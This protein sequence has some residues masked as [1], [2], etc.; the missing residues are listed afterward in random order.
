[1][2]IKNKESLEWRFDDRMLKIIPWGNGLRVRET[3]NDFINVDWALTEEVTPCIN[4][5]IDY[6]EKTSS[7]VNG[8]IK[9]VVTDYGKISFFNKENDLILE[10][11]WR[12]RRRKKQVNEE[13]DEFIDD[14]MINEFVSALKVEGRELRPRTEGDYSLTV[15]FE[16]DENEKIYGMGQYQQK[17]LDLKYCTLELA[18]RNSQ[19]SVPFALSSKGYGF[20]WNNPAIGSANFSKNITE[21]KAGD[22]RE[23]D[24]WI[25]A[26]ESPKKI[27]EAYTEV[28]GRTPQIPEYGLG[29]WQSKLRYRTQEELLEVAREYKK[30]NIPISVIVIDYF[31]WTCQG[32]FK[33]DPKFWP[34]PKEMIK[35]LKEMGIELMVSVWPTIDKKSE[36]FDE[37]LE[38]GLLVRSDKGARISMEFQGNTIFFDATNPESRSYVWNKAK[39]NYYDYGVKIF[40]LD[41]AEPEYSPY[42]FDLYRL[43]AG[44]NTQIGNI[45]PKM[46]SKTFFDGMSKSGQKDIIN[47]VRCAWA[48]SQKYGALVW[49]GDIDSSFRSLRYQYQCGLNMGM[50]GIPW[51]TT[52]I[53]GFHGGH[54]EDEEFKECMIRWFQYATFSP[55]LRM[56]GDREPHFKELSK[57]GGGTVKTGAPNEIWSYGD[58]A[59]KIMN[60]YIN[61]RE[62]LKPYI[63]EVMDEAHIN[64]SPV[65]RTLFFEFPED[66]ISW[67]IEDQHMFGGDL[68]VCPIMEYKSRERS[69]YLPVNEVWI[70]MNSKTEYSGGQ[71]VNI[72]APLEYIPVFVKKNSKAFE[73]LGGI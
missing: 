17:N 14:N 49:S 44:R 60:N 27:I 26:E 18:H 48:G 73:L 64:G 57:T 41:E 58:A 10:E 3:K 24:Y 70:S 72:E 67:N 11:Y 52:D 62:V 6:G 39:E 38:K 29:L 71:T 59:Y 45:F 55:V 16:S 46:F 65:M 53:G 30:R 50:A 19:A 12:V 68:L 37:M 23:V 47:L 22:T 7:I 69:V 15:R 61:I 5:Q 34:N 56:H 4:F 63:K 21:W 36:N 54:I 35:E 33:F 9:A 13:S 51:W 42:D 8:N 43:K 2:F 31:H 28:T 25:C 66:K 40:W 32:D 20:L 1:M